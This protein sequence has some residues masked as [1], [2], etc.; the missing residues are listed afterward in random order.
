MSGHEL[1]EWMI[2]YQFEPFGVDAQFLGHAI[3]S[4][5]IANTNRAKGKRAYKV[6]DFMPKF[7][8]KKK[9]SAE[10]IFKKLKSILGVAKK[11]DPRKD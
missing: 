2:F 6:E 11:E 8:P 3:T 1:M 4:R 5:T 10:E 7:Q 9:Q